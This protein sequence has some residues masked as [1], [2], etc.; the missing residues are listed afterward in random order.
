L[1]NNTLHTLTTT[2]VVYCIVIAGCGHSL[3]TV[4]NACSTLSTSHVYGIPCH[5]IFKVRVID[6][7]SDTHQQQLLQNSQVAKS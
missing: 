1:S 4:R 5:C 3:H 6:C 2:H 7:S